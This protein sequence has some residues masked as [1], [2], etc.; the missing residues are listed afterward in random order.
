MAKTVRKGKIGLGDIQM[1]P[2]DFS[3]TT[4]TGGTQTLSGFPFV[5]VDPNGQYTTI[6]AALNAAGAKVVIVPDTY[7]GAEETSIAAG[8]VVIDLRNGKPQYRSLGIYTNT[9]MNL[10]LSSILNGAD[11]S[12]IY[13]ASYGNYA[14]EALTGAIDVPDGSTIYQANAVSGYIKASDAS[15]NSVAGFFLA[16][17]NING[18]SV[19]GLNPVVIGST[20]N[21]GVTIT[22]IEVDVNVNNASSVA[23]GI[24][25]QGSWS[26]NPTTAA[27]IRL[28]TPG[29]TSRKWTSF[30]SSDDS[31]TDLGLFLGAQG[32]TSA[33]SQR[34]D[35]QSRNAG[36]T[37][38]TSKIYSD[39]DGHLTLN[40]DSGDDIIALAG[41]VQQD[42]K[43]SLYN[44]ISTVGGGIAA[45]YATADLTAQGAAIAATT[46]YAVPASG[47]GTYRI[48]FAA[49]VT[50]AAT[51]SCILGGTNGF[52]IVYTDADDSVVV[53]TPAGVPF[54]ST[55]VLLA[56]NSTQNQYSGVIIVRA[57][58]STN[59]QYSFGYTSV[60]ATPMQFALHIKVEAL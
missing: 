22:G 21:T 26:A 14:T 3:R 57:K 15:T 1:T 55:T 43:T 25:L 44:G 49:K 47:A 9:Q 11:P 31:S 35:L 5:V 46:I 48:S 54:N 51:T 60:G 56:T 42:G 28:I 8:Q 18:A 40:P 27:G 4:S 58:E 19:W 52:Q 36:G 59:I 39:L 29:G 50:Q 13:F 30:L 7:A 33:S 10:L 6:Q 17:T 34:I 37:A 12:A 23:Q 20:A 53:T 38:K 16:Q 45:E 41:T 24:T 32:A 2:G